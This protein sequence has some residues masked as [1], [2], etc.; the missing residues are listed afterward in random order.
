MREHEI[1]ALVLAGNSTPQIAATLVVSPFTVQQH[2]KS[3]FEKSGVRS[4][5]ELVAN[6]LAVHYGSP[7]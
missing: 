6:L 2:L 5:R 7:G 4:R 3:I 1:A